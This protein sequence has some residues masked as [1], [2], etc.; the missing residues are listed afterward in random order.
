M[1]KRITKNH[2]LMDLIIGILLYGIVFEVIGVIFGMDSVRGTLAGS[3]FWDAVFSY[4][5]VESILWYSI[6]LW[7][8]IATGVAGAVSMNHTIQKA[9]CY[10]EKDAIA[11]AR[12]GSMIR[13]GVLWVIIIIFS[14]CNGSAI[15]ATFIGILGLKISA[16]IQPLI[17]KLTSIFFKEEVL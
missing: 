4:I 17:H 3:A 15:L 11:V 2:T 14:M 8:G 12:K 1:K 7:L 5:F 9:V 13:Y 16:Y 10:E 6:S